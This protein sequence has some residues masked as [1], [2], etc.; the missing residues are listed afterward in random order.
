MLEKLTLTFSILAILVSVASVISSAL[1]KRKIR[2]MREE[3]LK[4]LEERA[5][6]RE[7]L[8]RIESLATTV[9]RPPA[10]VAR[11]IASLAKAAQGTPRDPGKIQYFRLDKH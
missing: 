3:N 11:D 5:D 8:A 6:G 9:G 2:R 7:L 4:L 10:E 1:H